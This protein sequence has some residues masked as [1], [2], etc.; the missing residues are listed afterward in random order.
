MEAGNCPL[1]WF[2]KGPLPAGLVN[3]AASALEVDYGA[4]YRFCKTWFVSALDEN[5]LIWR[6]RNQNKHGDDLENLKPW[7]ELR[8]DYCDAVKYL[9]RIGIDLP[10]RDQ[11]KSA[12]RVQM[13]NYIDKADNIRASSSL[14]AHITANGVSLTSDEQRARLQEQRDLRRK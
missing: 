14:L 13:Q 6:A 12:K 10:D 11:L 1:P 9:D 3:S 2:T 8:K 7:V 5:L 4:A